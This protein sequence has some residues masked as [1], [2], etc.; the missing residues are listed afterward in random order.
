MVETNTAPIGT[1]FTV[2][3]DHRSCQTGI[4]AAERA[5]TVRAIIDPSQQA[6]DFRRPATCS[7]W[8]P[9]KAAC[10]AAPGTPRRP[11]TWPAWPA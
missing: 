8:W 3:V 7:R 11:S 9:R 4:S 1:P 5:R 6:G 10:S 2:P